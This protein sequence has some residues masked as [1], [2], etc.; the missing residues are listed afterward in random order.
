V[1]PNQRVEYLCFVRVI[2]SLINPLTNGQPT[3]REEKM[4]GLLVFLCSLDGC[5]L[6][7]SAIA[8][9]PMMIDQVDGAID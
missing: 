3:M 8:K 9:I 7:I 4:I 1:L 2:D 6:M 5:A